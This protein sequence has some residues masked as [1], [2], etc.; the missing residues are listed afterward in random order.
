MLVASFAGTVYAFGKQEQRLTTI[1]KNTDGNLTRAH[2]EK[3]ALEAQLLS[4]GVVPVTAA[5]VGEPSPDAV[6]QAA[7]A[8]AQ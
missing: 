7:E 4:L 8:V 3:A 2:N 6:V 5:K 1:E